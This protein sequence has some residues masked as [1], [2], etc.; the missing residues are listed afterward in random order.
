M[1]RFAKNIYSSKSNI[2]PRSH[3]AVSQ[4]TSLSDV[5]LYYAV[6][7][8]TSWIFSDR[9]YFRSALTNLNVQITDNM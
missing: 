4:G 8:P 9:A 2:T 7:D 5:H 3:P 6:Q 1:G